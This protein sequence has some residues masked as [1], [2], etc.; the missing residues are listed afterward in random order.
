MKASAAEAARGE[1]EEVGAFPAGVGVVG[2]GMSV[3]AGPRAGTGAG[4]GAGEGEG[5]GLML[6]QLIT[7]TLLIER[8]MG[9]SV[10]KKVSESE[11]P[12]TLET[13]LVQAESE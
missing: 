3:G 1:E 11:M 13:K 10:S 12:V 9:C 8:A 7:T 2:A 6:R 4:P 5:G